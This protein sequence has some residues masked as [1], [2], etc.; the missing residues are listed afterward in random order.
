MAEQLTNPTA[1]V[2]DSFKIVGETIARPLNW[3][4]STLRIEGVV[5]LRWDAFTDLAKWGI[6]I[7]ALVCASLSIDA[8]SKLHKDHPCAINIDM[9]NLY[10]TF[11]S[12]VI[13]LFTLTIVSPYHLSLL[14]ELIIRWL[15]PPT[16][17]ALTAYLVYLTNA[18]AHL[19]AKE[20]IDSNP[21]GE[22]YT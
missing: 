17:I 5:L 3:I 21:Q 15:I 6:S 9:R 22:S 1:K 10:V 12:F 2:R 4:G 11:I 18:L 16:L 8:Y 19:S 13:I 14:F 20:L 7:A